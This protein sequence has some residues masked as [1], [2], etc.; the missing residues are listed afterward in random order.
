[1]T[2]SGSSLPPVDYPDRLMRPIVGLRV[3]LAFVGE[4]ELHQ[5]RKDQL[6]YVIEGLITVETTQGIWTVPPHCAIWIPGG[7]PHFG[8]A[9]GEVAIGNLYIEPGQSRVQR[10]SCEILFIQPLLREL[11]LRFVEEPD[12]YPQGDVR[13]QHLVDVLMDELEAAP[14][15]PLRL[16]MPD[17]RRLKRL[18]HMLMSEPSSRL[19]MAEWGAKVGAS[20]RTLTRL[21][22]R[23]TGVS[24]GRWRQQMHIGMALQRLAKGE[25]ITNI[26][27]DLGYESISAFSAMFRRVLGVSPRQYLNIAPARKAIAVKSH[28]VR[29]VGE[30]LPRAHPALSRHIA[31]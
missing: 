18:V 11:V 30:K 9:T 15:Q 8:R 23:E 2:M 20:N 3:E 22:Q 28:T 10:N 31:S 12:R 19:T 21:F 14:L 5:H 27:L 4:G 1:V 6:L 25:P 17:D 16:P 26:A 29:I 24:F 7:I 13:E